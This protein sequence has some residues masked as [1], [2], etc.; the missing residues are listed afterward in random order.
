MTIVD[1][2]SHSLAQTQR[3]GARLGALLQPGDVLLLRGPLG[4][5]KTSFTQGVAEGL[6]IARVVNS[7]TFVLAR[8]YKGRL[9]LYHMDF[10]RLN[11]PEEPANLGFDEYF[12]GQGVAV[13]EW[14]ERAVGMPDAALDVTFKYVSDTKRGVRMEP[15]GERYERLLVEFRR[16]AFGV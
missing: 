1:V 4:S 16:M 10:Y 13:V 7:P 3:L 12:Y 11:Q 9:P 15:R 2:V 6:G 8:E 14:P 5:G